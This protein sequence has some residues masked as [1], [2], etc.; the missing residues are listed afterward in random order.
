MIVL[1]INYYNFDFKFNEML[2]QISQNKMENIQ[3]NKKEKLLTYLR[4]T[5]E[6]SFE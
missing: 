4:K 5:F 6:N 3:R 1:E 2:N